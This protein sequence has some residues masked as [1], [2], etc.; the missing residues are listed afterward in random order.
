MERLNSEIDRKKEQ[1]QNLSNLI[2][3][4]KRKISASQKQQ[5]R[6]QDEQQQS[7]FEKDYVN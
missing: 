4:S 5:K 1:L 7:S 6:D 2:K 3:S